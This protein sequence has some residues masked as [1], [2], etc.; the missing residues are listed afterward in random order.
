MKLSSEMDLCRNEFGYHPVNTYLNI[1]CALCYV[2]T[3]HSTDST[4]YPLTYHPD[5]YLTNYDALPDG[6]KTLRQLYLP[7]ASDRNAPVYS[8]GFPSWEVDRDAEVWKQCCQAAA[9]CC[10][11]QQRAGNDSDCPPTWDGWQCWRG[12]KAGEIL[13][14]HCPRH[15]QP[16]ARST[17]TGVA[18]KVCTQ[19][20]TWYAKHAGP[21]DPSFS[22]EWTNYTEC[23]NLSPLESRFQVQMVTYCISIAFLV[24]ALLIFWRCQHLQVQR[25]LIHVNFFVS[26]LLYA[27]TLTVFHGL[28]TQQLLS[29][30][31]LLLLEHHDVWQCRVV[32]GLTKYFRLCNYCWMLC[33]GLF[34]LR[35]LKHVFMR[36]QRF[37]VYI[38]YGWGLPF[39]PVSIYAGV[40]WSE[41]GCWIEPVEVL[42]WLFKGPALLSLSLNFL[43]LW[44]IICL[45]VKKLQT[46]YVSE[47]GKV[48]KSFRAILVLM[49]LFGLH[50]VIT[51]YRPADSCHTQ[52]YFYLN[53]ALDGLQ[54]FFVSVTFCYCNGEVIAV[55]KR[56]LRLWRLRRGNM[57]RSDSA[58]I[59][60]LSTVTRISPLNSVRHSSTKSTKSPHAR[61]CRYDS[62]M[63]TRQSSVEKKELLRKSN[64]SPL[65]IETGM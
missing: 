43:F 38:L 16:F 63:G 6:N 49:P 44:Y 3:F 46:R 28:V 26:L 54:G 59:R 15:I 27:I 14:G 21:E 36:E 65:S 48:R 41:N 52:W 56:S 23:L 55:F 8:V 60:S 20:G 37:Y 24:P 1:T 39:L 18:E 40:R 29:D 4:N 34:L 9:D 47:I 33:E 2:Y 45:L 64:S 19:N 58:A 13:Q 10:S 17:C 25:N 57:P 53:N 35:H 22:K 30:P 12:A 11:Q 32:Y 7:L 5:G 42:E 62:L 61:V 50:F 51:A 31:D